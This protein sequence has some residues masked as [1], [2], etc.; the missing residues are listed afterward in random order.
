[1]NKISSF[2][3]S[4]VLHIYDHEDMAYFNRLLRKENGLEATSPIA[5]GNR[6]SKGIWVVNLPF[7]SN[8]TLGTKFSNTPLRFDSYVYAFFKGNIVSIQLNKSL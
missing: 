4:Q 6:S 1:M 2:R 3:Q 8:H 5:K 7:A